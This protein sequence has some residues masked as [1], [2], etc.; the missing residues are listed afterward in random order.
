MAKTPAQLNGHALK[1]HETVVAYLFMLPALF[2]FVAFVILPMGIGIVTS[3]FNYT[4]KNSVSAETFIGL[5]TTSSCSRT[6]NSSGPCGIPS[7][8]WW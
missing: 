5:K 8:W 3:L 1:R 4:M 2:F 6:R 7:S